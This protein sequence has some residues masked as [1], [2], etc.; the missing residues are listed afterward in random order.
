MYIGNSVVVNTLMRFPILI[1]AAVA[2]GVVV[3]AQPEPVIPPPVAIVAP[4]PPVIRQPVEHLCPPA[5]YLTKKELAKRTPG[6]RR[7][8]KTRGCIKG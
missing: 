4:A 2:A 1:P 6:E 5:E 7:A 8:L 3:A